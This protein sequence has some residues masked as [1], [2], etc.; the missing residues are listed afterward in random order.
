MKLNG[1]PVPHRSQLFIIISLGGIP[2]SAT[3]DKG[4]GKCTR[5]TC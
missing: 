5:R 2:A 4:K 1:V 3:K